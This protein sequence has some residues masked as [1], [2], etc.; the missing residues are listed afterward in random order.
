MEIETKKGLQV[1]MFCKG[2]AS[3]A[4]LPLTTKA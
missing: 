1:E 4:P 2:A 3:A